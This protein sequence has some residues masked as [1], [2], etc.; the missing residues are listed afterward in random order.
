MEVCASRPVI[1]TGFGAPPQ[2]WNHDGDRPARHGVV[3]G[4]VGDPT[5]GN[6]VGERESGHG[7]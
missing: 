1:G 3:A 5:C 4:G 2:T 6:V 7:G